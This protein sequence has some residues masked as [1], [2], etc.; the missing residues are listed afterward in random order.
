MTFLYAVALLYNAVMYQV[1][2]WYLCRNLGLETLQ[3]V[4]IGVC[5]NVAAYA[6]HG[7]FSTWIRSKYPTTEEKL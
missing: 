7:L 5:A 2:A 1:L 6:F 3:V 4:A